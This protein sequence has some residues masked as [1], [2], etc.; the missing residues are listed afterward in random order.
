MNSWF[1]RDD[2]NAPGRSSIATEVGIDRHEFPATIRSIPIFFSS[3]M[4][5]LN[6]K[7]ILLGIFNINLLFFKF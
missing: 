7:P 5:N 3:N 4:I 6:T 1:D 2:D